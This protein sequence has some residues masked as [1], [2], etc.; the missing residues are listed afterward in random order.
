MIETIA[1]RLKEKFI[2]KKSISY[3]EKR[4]KGMLEYGTLSILLPWK[5]NGKEKMLV[6]SYSLSKGGIVATIS[7]NKEDMIDD[8]YTGSSIDAAYS[9]IIQFIWRYFGSEKINQYKKK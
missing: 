4:G 6:V 1:R 9:S 2:D 7:I 5:H 3:F 8:V